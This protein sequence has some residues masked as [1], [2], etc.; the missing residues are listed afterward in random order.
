M[1]LRTHYV[2]SLGLLFLI[3]SLIIDTSLY[4][5]ILTGIISVVGNN[6]IDSLGHE[7]KGKYITRTPRTHTLS[8]SILWGLV[9]TIPLAIILYYFYPDYYLVSIIVLDG[10]IVG[11]SHMLLDIF[12]ERGIYHKVNG[13]WKRIALAHFSYN[14][15]FVNG[16]AII[17]GILMLFEAI[18]LHISLLH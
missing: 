15:P 2:F 7:T 3:D 12:T 10:V 17:L 6:I 13:K 11:L 5:L 4:L 16:L 9:V 1:E 18:E 8:R 14:N